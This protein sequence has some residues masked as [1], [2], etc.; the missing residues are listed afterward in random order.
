[1]E[2]IASV[3]GATWMVAATPA[4]A[5]DSTAAEDAVAVTAMPVADTVD[6]AAAVPV[7]E[8]G[9]PWVPIAALG[10]GDTRT[11]I[12]VPAFDDV[13]LA[14]GAPAFQLATSTDGGRRWTPG[15]TGP[16]PDSVL[17][18]EPDYTTGTIDV[19]VGTIS[20][21]SEEARARYRFDAAAPTTI[22]PAYGAANLIRGASCRAGD[23]TWWNPGDGAGIAWSNND[24]SGQILLPQIS[25][26]LR[27]A[28]CTRDA[29]L[30][31]EGS[32]PV[33]YHRCVIQQ[34]TEAFRGTTY[35]FGRA[36]MKP[37]GSVVYAA[38]RGAVLALWHESSAEPTYV[39]L[40]RALT[41]DALVVWGGVPHAL[42]H[43]PK[44]AS[45]ALLA[46][47]LE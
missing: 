33:R 44:D 8:V 26:D 47:K 40:P 22:P 32:V 24:T 13:P 12:L 38:G 14:P 35:A 6:F 34:C 9:S 25:G 2:A 21:Y 17:Y 45:A 3:P 39:K 16:G 27:V 42:L 5:F 18:A 1:M 28:D 11:V 23:A 15:A 29:A 4:R 41:L 36:A 46:V 20:D 30:V 43:D 7:V 19:V 10:D 31:E 37:D